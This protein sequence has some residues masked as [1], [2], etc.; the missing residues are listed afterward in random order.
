[1]MAARPL[2]FHSVMI[3][4]LFQHYKQLTKL[5][6]EIKKKDF[7]AAVK[8]MTDGNLTLNNWTQ[9]QKPEY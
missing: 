9:L 1:M 5:R 2:V 7:Q 4:I 8:I 6:G 3:S